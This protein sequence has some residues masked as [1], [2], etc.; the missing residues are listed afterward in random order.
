MS[1]FPFCG[2]GRIIGHRNKEPYVNNISVSEKSLKLHTHTT[3]CRSH[4]FYALGQKVTLIPISAKFNHNLAKEHIS[5]CNSTQE[6]L[7]DTIGYIW[8]LSNMF[9]KYTFEYF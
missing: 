9:S 2:G 5:L 1:G 7:L 3:S 8:I 6:V 4:N